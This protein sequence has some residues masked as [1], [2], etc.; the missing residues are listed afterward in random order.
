VI[1][2]GQRSALVLA[3]QLPAVSGLAKN[4]RYNAQG[5]LKALQVDKDS[6]ENELDELKP[7]MFEVLRLTKSFIESKILCKNIS[8]IWVLY[9]LAD[10]GQLINRDR[11]N[12][13][14][15]DYKMDVQVK[16]I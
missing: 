3:A 1:L 14:I 11:G 13:D 15:F 16:D 6:G 9:T 7:R 8:E 5:M 4:E 10:R 12:R 2:F